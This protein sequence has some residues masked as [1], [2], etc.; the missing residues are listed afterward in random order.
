MGDQSGGLSA[1]NKGTEQDDDG[2]NS[3]IPKKVGSL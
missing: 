3:P 1:N 2:K